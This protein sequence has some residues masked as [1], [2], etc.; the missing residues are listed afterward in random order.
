MTRPTAAPRVTSARRRTSGRTHPDYITIARHETYDKRAIRKLYDSRLSDGEICVEDGN[1]YRRK[2]AYTSDLAYDPHLEAAARRYAEQLFPR[3]FNAYLRSGWRNKLPVKHDPN[4]HR[5]MWGENIL[6]M[7]RDWKYK[8][9]DVGDLIY[10]CRKANYLWYDEIKDYD[11]GRGL[12]RNGKQIGHFTQMVWQKTERVGYAVVT[13]K[14]PYKRNHNVIFALLVAKY[15]RPGNYIGQ[16][17][18]N[19]GRVVT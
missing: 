7:S 3:V 5:N 2:H 19:I 17:V 16:V 8:Q 11:W 4:N 1:R 6:I 15:Q 14:D 13:R 18:H 10:Y 12:T 9:K